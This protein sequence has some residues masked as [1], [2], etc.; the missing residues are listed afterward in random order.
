[1]SAMLTCDV[2]VVGAGPTGLVLANLLGGMGIATV[3]L[4]RNETTVQEPRAVSIDDESM[5][6]MQALGLAE[7]VGATIASGYGSRYFGPDGRE[8]ARVEPTSREYG[9]DKR[10]AFEQPVLERLLREGVR[11]YP[12]VDMRFGHELSSFAEHDDGVRAIASGSDGPFDIRARYLVGCDGAR[13]A[14]RKSLG[15]ALVGS[16]FKER[17]LIVDLGAT[18]NRLR[19]TEVFCRPARAAISLPGPGAIRRYEFMLSEADEEAA[20]TEET[21]VRRLL[22]EHGVDGDAPIRRRQVYTFHARAARVW[23]VGRVLLAGDA[24]HLTPPF[25]GQ[26]M[27]SGVRDAHNLGW[28]LRLAIRGDDAILDT[29]QDERE[30][31]VRDMIAMALSMGKVMAP[32]DAVTGMATRLAFRILDVIPPAKRYFVQMRYKPKPRFR[33]GLIWPDGMPQ[34]R[35]LVGRLLPQPLVEDATRSG[36]LLDDVLGHGAH[37]LVLAERPEEAVPVEMV[38]RLRARG[39]EVVG[40]VPEWINPGAADFPVVRD[41]SRLLSGDVWRTYRE[42]AL[43][44]RPDRYVAATARVE[45]LPGLDPAIARL[46]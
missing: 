42:H 44:V 25:A 27:N 18:A 6:T 30:P 5:R 17:W 33:A 26:G 23:R 46:C 16:T 24:A 35:T 9:F 22:A 11:R 41:V 14:V 10:N 31:H 15:V 34:S 20:V 7:R 43:L 28:K 12:C 40:V 1:M 4:E 2:L 13:S 36:R 3:V 32:R 19:H 38:R 45:R 8:F 39:L 21:N 37:L 29:Y